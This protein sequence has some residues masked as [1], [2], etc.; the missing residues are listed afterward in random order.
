ME[1]LIAAVIGGLL[2]AIVLMRLI[3]TIVS[4]AVDNSLDWLIHTFGNENAARRVEE[5]WRQREGQ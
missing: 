1:L 3:W 5:K 2:L 4:G